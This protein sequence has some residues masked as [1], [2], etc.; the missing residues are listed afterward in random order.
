MF[1]HHCLT[2]IGVIIAVVASTASGL[3]TQVQYGLNVLPEQ[4]WLFVELLG[5]V[6]L[7]QLSLL[8][9]VQH[10]FNGLEITTIPIIVIAIVIIAIVIIVSSVCGG[11]YHHVHGMYVCMYVCMYV[12]GVL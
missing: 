9:I 8:I 10:L 2:G 6:L 3:V 11:I 1:D 7:Q 4:E 12:G 5:Q